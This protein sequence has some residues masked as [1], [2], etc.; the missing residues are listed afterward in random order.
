MAEQGTLR[1]AKDLRLQINFAQHNY[2]NQ[3]G[4]IRQLD[5]KAG[6]FVT[7]LVF[8]AAGAL[9]IA[10]DVSVKLHWHGRGAA[11]SWIYAVSGFT[12]VFGFLATSVCVQRVIRLRGSEH[13]S[14]STGLMFAPDILSHGDPE[15]YYAATESAT[16]HTLLKNLAVQVFQLSAIVKRKTDALRVARWPTMISFLAWAIN[17]VMGAYILMW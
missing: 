6:V 8:L 1:T 13:K 4:I 10:K 11:S 16:E 17:C 2:D 12:L 9:A 3:Q 14:L 7:L 5:V 15:A